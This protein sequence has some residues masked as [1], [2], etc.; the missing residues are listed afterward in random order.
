MSTECPETLLPEAERL[1]FEIL[2]RIAATP[3]K[4]LL[5]KFSLEGLQRGGQ[6]RDAVDRG[7]WLDYEW[8][9]VSFQIAYPPV[10]YMLAGVSSRTNSLPSSASVHR[11]NLCPISQSSR[12]A[13]ADR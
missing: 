13:A 2:P 3:E 4:L 6:I 9:G 7:N 12:S 5:L 1:W 11:K 10:G 8:Y